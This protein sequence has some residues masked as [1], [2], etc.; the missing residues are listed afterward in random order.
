MHQRNKE[1][2]DQYDG[3]PLKKSG[4]GLR[5][6]VAADRTTLAVL[7]HLHRTIGAFFFL[8]PDQFYCLLSFDL[9]LHRTL[10][11]DETDPR[12]F[13]KIDFSNFP[14]IK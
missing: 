13:C 3:N 6:F 9:I 12:A 10:G 11:L 2:N 8:T 1:K 4:L 14:M 7:W 5:K